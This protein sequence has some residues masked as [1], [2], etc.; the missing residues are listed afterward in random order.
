MK[1][2]F[3][4]ENLI[5]TTIFFLPIYLVK[6]SIF[7]ISTNL[8]ELMIIAALFLWVSKRDKKIALIIKENKAVFIFA[9]IIFSGL[10]V[11]TLIN[12]NYQVEWGIIKGWF[13]L[14]FLFAFMAQ[15]IFKEERR[16]ALFKAYFCST[17]AVAFISLVYFFAGTETYDGRLEAFFNSPNYLVMYLAPGLMIGIFNYK[18]DKLKNNLFYFL[19]LAIIVL[20][21]YLTKSYAGWLSIFLTIL[22][23]SLLVYRKKAKIHL[24]AGAVLFLAI[25]YFQ[26][27]T[28]KF[29]DLINI[30]ERSSVSSRIMIWA[31]A[32]RILADNWLWGIGPGKFQSKYLEYQKYFPPYLEWAV[33]H[34]HNLYLSFWL[35][36]GIMGFLGF[37]GLVLFWIKNFWRKIDRKKYIG[38][39]AILFYILIH[40]FFDTTY[41]KNDLAVVFW[42]AIMSGL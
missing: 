40:G 6:L 18:K 21:I 12:P 15:D 32:E 2:I 10:I 31:A 1:K 11:S 20:A 13:A 33:P 22:I 42:L 26:F 17:I 34:P 29:G 7:G 16:E 4:L 38:I 27:Q 9:G 23:A 24:I 3:N 36:G 37:L 25:I 28:T 5:L 8:L 39:L 30:N 35:S 41:F 19:A 14:P